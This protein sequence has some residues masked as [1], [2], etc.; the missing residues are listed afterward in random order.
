[1]FLSKSV[2]VK[3]GIIHNSFPKVIEEKVHI[4]SIYEEKCECVV[5]TD[6]PPSPKQPP[7]PPTEAN[8]EQIQKYLL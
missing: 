6:A 2:L 8:R 3:L 7:V 4:S 1:M 5:R